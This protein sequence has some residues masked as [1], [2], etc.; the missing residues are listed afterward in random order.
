MA[1]FM[2]PDFLLTTEAA[3]IL[4]HDYAEGCLIVDYH[5][6]LSPREI[7]E[8]RRFDNIAEAW[9]GGD[10]YKWRL[11]RAAGVEERFIT[12]AAP[13]REKF[14]RWAETLEKAVGNPLYPWSHLELSRFFGIREP[15]TGRNAGMV[16]E[17]CN[18]QLRAPSH[19]ARG[20]IEMSGVSV[21]CTTDDPAD[22]LEWHA[23][24]KNDPSFSTGVLP[25]WRPDRAMAIAPEGFA[26]YLRQLEAASGVEISGFSSLLRALFLRMDHFHAMGCRVSDHG[27]E[28]V[29]YAPADEA[30]VERIF[31]SR[32]AGR[33]LAPD[34]AQKF[35]TA[36]LLA[37]G[38]E[39]ARRGW[40]MQLHFGCLRNVNERIYRLLGADAG[41][42]A[43]G[44]G[45]SARDLASF[46]GAL[47]WEGAL[48]RTILYS[49]NPGDDDMIDALAGCF[50]GCEAV[51]K[52]QHGPA[53]WFNDH[54]SGMEKQLTSLANKGY[55][56]GFVGML[57]DSRSFLSYPRHEYFRRVLCRLLGQWVEEGQ[58]PE[59]WE[60]LGEIVRD[61][62]WRNAR[63]YFRLP[64]KQQ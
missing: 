60:A 41:C 8:N 62:C 27:L 14:Q 43:I 36:L 37:L 38:R 44:G 28:R 9:L 39:Y 18:A 48:P 17:T 30:E 32:L 20:L 19:S 45:Q 3:R 54:F 46:L 7:Y 29:P 42:D 31:Q 10:H 40:T 55:L 2:G 4:Y 16:W 15:L 35:S 63:H 6:H 23:L 50:Q 58:L 13:D 5:C 25:A 59:Q 64:E 47:D 52:V 61:I 11:M 21:L 49:L 24:L 56:A 26:D 57:T 12:G 1:E 22:A 34:D 51:C 33:A 53:W